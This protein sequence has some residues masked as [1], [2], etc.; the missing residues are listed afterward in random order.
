MALFIWTQA[1][2]TGNAFID[3]DHHTLVERVN[4]V[5]EAIA[6]VAPKRELGLALHEL[7]AYTREHFGQEEAQML[8]IHYAELDAH[9][10]EHAKLLAQ[11]DALKAE[12][13]ADQPIDAMGLYN[14]L[15]RWVKDHIVHDDTK[16]AAALK[17]ISG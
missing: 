14:F 16:L 15:T 9:R 1:L 13:D 4:A 5:L 6:Q 11:L 12:L 3:D 10:A 2:A 17:D 7:V 8:R